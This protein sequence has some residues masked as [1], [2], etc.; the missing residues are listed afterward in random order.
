MHILNNINK[1]YIHII[2]KEKRG[3]KIYW[4]CKCLLCGKIFYMR[5]DVLVHSDK[6]DCGCKGTK[7]TWNNK[8]RYN[9]TQPVDKL[10][11]IVDN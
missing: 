4:K 5:T 3:N 1:G 11:T 10:S 6:G 9:N 7:A 8:L 2:E